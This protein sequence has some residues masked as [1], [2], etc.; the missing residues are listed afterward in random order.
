MEIKTKT[1][2]LLTLLALILVAPNSAS[3]LLMPTNG[4][5]LAAMSGVDAKA[6]VVM[7]TSTGKL[8]IDN[9]SNLEWTPASLTKVVT[10]LVVMD[11]KTKLTKQVT[12]TKEDQ[13]KGAC[14]YGGICI[15][16]AVGVKFTVDGL[17]HAALLPSA[18]NAANALARSTGLS[19]AEFAERMNK[20]AAELGAINSRF[21][22]PTGM[23]P[24][25]K[26]TAGDY[27]K[28][29]TA[30]FS[31]NYLKSV[32]QKQNYTLKSVNNKKYNQTVKNNNKLLANKD[33]NIFG[34]KTG[35]LHES[36]YN[37]A[38]LLKYKNGPTLAIVVLG[39]KHLYTAF[40]ETNQLANLAKHA[41]DLLQL[42]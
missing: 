2:Y 12:M 29:I 6:Y 35:Y 25:N 21:Y 36:K 9:N 14:S 30:A 11:T 17:M 5:E 1:K 28:I 16:S 27:A 32:A 4:N 20:K 38:S 40:D 7:D 24:N 3:A 39:E 8:L 13:T 37:F 26:I 15:R 34:A 41:Q 18:N 31:N 33:L 42:Q 19:S 23:D 10:A 22:E